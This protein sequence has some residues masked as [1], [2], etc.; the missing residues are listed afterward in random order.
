METKVCLLDASALWAEIWDSAR[1]PHNCSQF[2]VRGG[3]QITSAAV[4]GRRLNSLLSADTGYIITEGRSHRTAPPERPLRPQSL[5]E[6]SYQAINHRQNSTAAVTSLL[7]RVFTYRCHQ[8]R[9]PSVQASLHSSFLFHAPSRLLHPLSP[10]LCFP[11]R[12]RFILFVDKMSGA[13]FTYRGH[14]DVTVIR[15]RVN[16]CISSLLFTTS[17]VSSNSDY[18]KPCYD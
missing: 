3:N 14:S 6:G 17:W 7:M 4:I 1:R 15:F 9:A 10:F 13:A 18:K 5:C 11:C 2:N 16:V 12:T 8:T